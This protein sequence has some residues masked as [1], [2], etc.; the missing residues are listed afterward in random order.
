MILLFFCEELKE[1][2]LCC[3]TI[4]FVY[5]IASFKS[6]P[7][8]M[9]SIDGASERYY[10]DV[11]QMEIMLLLITALSLKSRTH[12]SV[13]V[14]GDKKRWK[15][16]IISACVG[17]HHATWHDSSL[18]PEQPL[19][20]A[21]CCLFT[22]V[23]FLSLCFK[24]DPVSSRKLPALAD[25]QHA[26]GWYCNHRG[27]PAPPPPTPPLRSVIL[28]LPWWC[29]LHRWHDAAVGQRGAQSEWRV[30]ET[31]LFSVSIIP[32]PPAWQTLEAPFGSKIVAK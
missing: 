20:S 3:Q 2:R 6:G 21:G 7:G 5:N 27:R 18:M 22:A 23:G 28:Q 31:F 30:G 11:C 32:F 14:T 9:V 8:I 17:F 10:C 4:I 19:L 29:G 1:I 16:L 12:C 26:A 13:G 25:S 24:N 15:W